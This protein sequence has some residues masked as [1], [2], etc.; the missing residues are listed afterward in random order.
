[1]VYASKEREYLDLEAE[2]CRAVMQSA[3]GAMLIS[4][5][6]KYEYIH[7]NI[8][9]DLRGLVFNISP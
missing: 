3:R 1:M 9:S 4:R 5:K 8:T 6:N 7:Q 2:E